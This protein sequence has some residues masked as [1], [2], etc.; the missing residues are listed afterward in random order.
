MLDFLTEPLQYNFLKRALISCVCLALG[1]APVGVLL[2]LRRMSLMGDAL[3]HAVLPGAAIGYIIAGLSL[4]ILGISGFIA[5]LLVAL[6][7]GIVSRYTALKEDASFAGFFLIA[8]ALGVL[9][10][11]LKHSAIDLIHIL[12][13][14]ALAV[15][16][17][18]LIIMGGITTFTLLTLATIV[19]PLLI[20]CFDPHFFK[21]SGGKGGRYH[22]LLLTLVVLNLVSGFQALG[23][24]LSLG[25]M[26]LPA[27]TARFWAQRIWNI[28]IFSILIALLSGTIGLLVSYYRDW[29]SGP[30]IVLVSGVFYI[31]SLILG[32]QG[33][34]RYY[35]RI[36]K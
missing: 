25:I 6:L 3:S 21:A 28:F 27:I 23:T 36:N 17:F 15:D 31:L 32:P 35:L 22:A 12:F 19:R 26:M 8:L 18:S 2:V 11:S 1:S 5:G 33:S 20:E 30:S 7:S 16:S 4:P 29:P 34:M 10:I 9:L 24:L 13:G 14:S